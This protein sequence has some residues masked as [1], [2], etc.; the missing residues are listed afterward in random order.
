M[1]AYKN[2]TFTELVETVYTMM[3]ID[4]TR[5]DFNIHFVTKPSSSLPASKFLIKDDYG[6][7]FIM[8]D[9]SK[10]KVIC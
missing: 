6:V 7:R 9:E 2:V 10:Y 3:G 4:K 8:F 1:A 5:Y